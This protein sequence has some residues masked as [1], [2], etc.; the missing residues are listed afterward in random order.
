MW[1]HIKEVV[2]STYNENIELIVIGD[3]RAKA[4]FIPSELPEI[5][6]FNLSLGGATPVEGYYILK[7]YLKGHI[8]IIHLYPEGAKPP[9]QI[10]HT[11]LFSRLYKSLPN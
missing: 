3:S 4:A 9:K 6:S 11:S 5:N 7:K 1:Y 2:N 8:K 10:D